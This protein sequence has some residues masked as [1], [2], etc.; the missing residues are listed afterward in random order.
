[1]RGASFAPAL[2]TMGVDPSS[3]IVQW[4]EVTRLRHT[5]WRVGTGTRALGRDRR[6]VRARTEMGRR[7]L[8]ERS[9]HRTERA[10]GA[11]RRSVLPR[12]PSR[13]ARSL[14][15]S[16]GQR[17][18]RRIATTYRRAC[19]ARDRGDASSASRRARTRTKEGAARR[20]GRRRRH[21]LHRAH[22]LGG[23]RRRRLGGANGDHARRDDRARSGAHVSRRHGDPRARCVRAHRVGPSSSRT[24]SSPCS[25][26]TTREGAAFQGATSMTAPLSPSIPAVPGK[27]LGAV[28]SALVPPLPPSP[29]PPGAPFAPTVV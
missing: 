27:P 29:R 1:M 25:S 20:T 15:P 28:P 26:R 21:R 11:I 8:L 19:A 6:C 22:L 24:E 5:P 3:F 18:V 2:F 14:S 16:L 12:E 13:R 4:V 17:G 7:R 10:G 23:A 9:S